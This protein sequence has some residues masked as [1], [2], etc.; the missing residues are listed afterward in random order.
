MTN[1]QLWHLTAQNAVKGNRNGAR[2]QASQF[3]SRDRNNDRI[4]WEVKPDPKKKVVR[5]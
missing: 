3:A 2:R 1:E 4:S 5:C